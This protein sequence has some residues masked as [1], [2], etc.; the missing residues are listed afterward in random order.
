M[1]TNA[2]GELASFHQFVAIK[3]AENQ[4]DLS[5]EDVL[6]LWRGEHPLTDED[7]DAVAAVEEALADIEAGDEGRSW[8]EFNEEFRQRHGLD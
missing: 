4:A 5:P 8:E 2:N 6:D 7:A 1:S 3:L